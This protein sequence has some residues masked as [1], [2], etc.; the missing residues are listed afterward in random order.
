MKKNA[1]N[2]QPIGGP[3]AAGADLWNATVCWPVLEH[4]LGSKRNKANPNWPSV[5]VYKDDI[6]VGILLPGR[7]SLLIRLS[8]RRRDPGHQAAL[9]LGDGIHRRQQKH[10]GCVLR[11][12]FETISSRERLQHEQWARHSIMPSQWHDL[13]LLWSIEIGRCTRSEATCRHHLPFA[14]S[15][16]ST[17]RRICLPLGGRAQTDFP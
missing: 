14:F 12:Q 7:L 2:D 17:S 15:P 5:P 16:I 6:S 3:Y 11:V 4:G 8:R 10:S 9:V 1:S 13:G